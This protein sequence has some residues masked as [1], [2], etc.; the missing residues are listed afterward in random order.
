[1][2]TKV[3]PTPFTP[4]WAGQKA[5]SS[6]A[7]LTMKRFAPVS[8]TDGKLSV[9]RTQQ[10]GMEGA[11]GTGLLEVLSGEQGGRAVA[12]EI[13]WARESCREWSRDLPGSRAWVEPGRA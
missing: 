13:L 7:S 1:M 11:V 9:S 4:P 10:W 6:F 3:P 5:R 12:A 2:G 8:R